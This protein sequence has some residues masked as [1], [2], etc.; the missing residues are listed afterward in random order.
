M[1]TTKVYPF[2]YLGSWRHLSVKI[3]RSRCI[4][5][6]FKDETYIY[7]E[8][9]YQIASEY[10]QKSR[11]YYVKGAKTSPS[12]AVMVQVSDWAEIWYIASIY[13]YVSSLK[14]LTMH[15]E[16]K[17]LTDKWRQ[18]PKYIA[19][20]FTHIIWKMSINGEVLDSLCSNEKSVG[21]DNVL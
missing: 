20:L 15:L 6:T 21:A 8:A 5:K 3:F 12:C 1:I 2:S 13:I 9:I 18:L 11:I 19:H 17:I 10:G 7:M 4:V 16:R 14:V